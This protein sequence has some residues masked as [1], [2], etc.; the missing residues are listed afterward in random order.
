MSVGE[1]RRQLLGFL[2]LVAVS[3]PAGCAHHADR[4][5]AIRASYY[6]GDLAAAR[7]EIDRLLAEPE[8]DADVLRLDRAMIDLTSGR[9]HEAEQTLRQV[10]ERMGLLSPRGASSRD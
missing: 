5:H 6:S 2:A 8:E 9:P 7:A 10:R 1:M 3:V 4:L